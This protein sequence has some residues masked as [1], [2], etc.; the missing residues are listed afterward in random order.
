MEGVSIDKM[1]LSGFSVLI[2]RLH[3]GVGG[4]AFTV[5]EYD[6]LKDRYR[7][8]HIRRQGDVV[9]HILPAANLA[10]F[11][12]R[13]VIGLEKAFKERLIATELGSKPTFLD[14]TD[15]VFIDL[16]VRC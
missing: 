14:T 5:D 10:G 4:R 11:T 3:D 13:T 9:D 6:C 8:G 7:L 2:C 16:L 1:D 15:R 12:G